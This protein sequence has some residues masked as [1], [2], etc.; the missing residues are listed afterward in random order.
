LIVNFWK[1][2]EIEKFKESYESHPNIGTFDF[3]LFNNRFK[4]NRMYG[5]KNILFFDNGRDFYGK[6]K[7]DSTTGWLNIKGT[8]NLGAFIKAQSR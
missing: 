1:Y 8:K 2:M 3:T 6:F 4:Q 7:I 5:E